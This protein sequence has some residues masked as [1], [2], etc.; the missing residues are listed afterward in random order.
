[1]A[2]LRSFWLLFFSPGKFGGK[3]PTQLDLGFLG[4]SQGQPSEIFISLDHGGSW[5]GPQPSSE[6]LAG[7]KNSH[8]FLDKEGEQRGTEGRESAQGDIKQALSLLLTSTETCVAGG[9]VL[10]GTTMNWGQEP[11]AACISC[12]CRPTASSFSMDKRGR[13]GS[14]KNAD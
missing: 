1:M 10:G 14:V 6:L 8:K 9:E 13:R 3:S 11:R 12:N 7:K 2:F 4:A 5:G